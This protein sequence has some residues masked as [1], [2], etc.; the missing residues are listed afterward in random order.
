MIKLYL[1]K[2]YAFVSNF[3]TN[4]SIRNSCPNTY[5]QNKQGTSIALTLR[6]NTILD[7]NMY[8]IGE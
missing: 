8:L 6:Y 4:I 1:D 7:Y 5:I 2:Y 3:L